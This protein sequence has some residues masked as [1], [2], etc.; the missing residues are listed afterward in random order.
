[1]PNKDKVMAAAAGGMSS[2]LG[3]NPNI[4]RVVENELTYAEIAERAYSYWEARGCQG[5]SAE[6]D[7]RKAIQ[8][9]TEERQ[10]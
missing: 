5:G 7:W 9:L 8:E 1:M 4:E 6:E 2:T 3:D 10:G